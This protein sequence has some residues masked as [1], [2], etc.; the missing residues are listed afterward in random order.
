MLMNYVQLAARTRLL[1]IILLLSLVGYLS[2][3]QI[4]QGQD[5]IFRWLV[6]CVPLLGCLPGLVR[7]QFRAGSWLCFVLLIYFIAFVA[8]LGVPGHVYGESL[9]V[10]L[11]VSLF[12]S[13]MMYARWQ[14][15]ANS[16]QGE[17]SP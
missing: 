13:A 3:H 2:V 7:A 14:Q 12:V 8:A 1:S 11:T 17:P 9:A 10:F 6:S 4:L 5:V 16:A 15:R